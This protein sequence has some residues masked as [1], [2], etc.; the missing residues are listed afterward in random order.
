MEQKDIEA[1]VERRAKDLLDQAQS[2]DDKC[3]SDI[4]KEQLRAISTAKAVE[5]KGLQDAVV[6]KRKEELLASADTDLKRETVKNKEI[7]IQLQEADYGVYMGVAT[8]AGIKK[9]LPH[10]MQNVLFF[11][12]SVFQ[13][14]FLVL[15]GIPVSIINMTADGV[16]SVVKKLAG[17]TKSAMWIVLAAI[18][19]V[20]LV[21]LFYFAKYLLID[22][23]AL[24]G[25]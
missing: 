9:P 10:K 14:I 17:L 1:L 6:D 5:D 21:V 11:V 7:D 23:G 19:V 12:L 16:D 3:I 15:L 25:V 8:Y 24:K 22:F 13:T 20:A 4:A 2:Q 18:I